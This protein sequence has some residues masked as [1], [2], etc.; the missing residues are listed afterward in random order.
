MNLKIFNAMLIGV[1]SLFFI[2]GC[3][4]MDD[5]PVE[6]RVVGELDNAPTWV[7]VPKTEGYISTVGKAPYTKDSFINQ[8]DAAIKISYENLS[9]KLEIKILNIFKLLNDSNANVDQEQYTLKSA[10]ATKEIVQTILNN[11]KILKLYKSNA[12]NIYVQ[13][14]VSIELVKKDFEE[15]INTSFKDMHLIIGNY[16]LHKEQGRIDLELNK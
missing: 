2:T 7:S 9:I 5:A 6:K 15:L 16:K 3:S 14:S 11:A 12:D 8:R 4:F 1:I 10:K 13:S